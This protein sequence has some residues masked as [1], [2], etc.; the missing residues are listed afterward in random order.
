VAAYSDRFVYLLR[1]GEG[2]YKVGIARD[3]L[4][5]IKTIQTGNSYPVELIAAVYVPQSQSVEQELHEWLAEHRTDGGRE[6]FDLSSD[7]IVELIKRMT[8]LS[9]IGDLS[10]YMNMLNLIDRQTRVEKRLERF[11]AKHDAPEV[12]TPVA[13]DEDLELFDEA[14]RIVNNARKASASMLQRRMKVGY[15]RAARLLD[16]L[17][18]AGIVGQA[19]GARPRE[20]LT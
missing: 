19:D 7:Q 17:E 2:H 6:W 11:L 10:G 18:E 13:E 5:R 15:A 4:K 8:E 12:I 20:V 3:V 1:A 14:V 16:R 9:M